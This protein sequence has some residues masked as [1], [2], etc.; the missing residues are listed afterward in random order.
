MPVILTK[1]LS[2]DLS[3]GLWQITESTEVLLSLLPA[4]I[5]VA[6]FE[7]LNI[8]KQQLEWLSSRLLCATL[9]QNL[10]LAASPIHK[11]IYGKPFLVDA[12]FQI[13]IAHSFPYA[14]VALHQTRAIGVDI[15]AH[16][17][18]IAAVARRVFHAEELAWATPEDYTLLWCA[19]E[20]MYKC[21]GKRSVDFRQHLRV[22]KHET[23]YAGKLLLEQPQN[24][25]EMLLFEENI[26]NFKIVICVAG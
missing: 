3:L 13:S 6:D 18:K 20:A 26:D 2:E 12:A 17:N 25:Q 11:D 9:L 21:Y 4:H 19:K 15:E 22:H 7:T 10:G 1:K 5:N 24:P 14:T 8:E 16:S 23:G